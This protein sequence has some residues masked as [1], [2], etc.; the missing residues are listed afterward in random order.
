MNLLTAGALT[1]LPDP[2]LLSAGQLRTCARMIMH[3]WVASVGWLRR[4]H[5]PNHNPNLSATLLS[6][7]G[8]ATNSSIQPNVFPDQRMHVICFRGRDIVKDDFR[9]IFNYLF[10]FLV[11]FFILEIGDA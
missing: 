2:Q 6:L 1:A 4:C 8:G 10:K 5:N 3:G 11:A 9:R 7:P